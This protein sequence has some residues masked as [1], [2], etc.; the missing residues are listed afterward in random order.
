MPMEGTFDAT[1]FDPAQGTPIHPPA[2]KIP[3]TITDTEIV[4][5]SAGNGG[6]LAIEFTTPIGVH[7]GRYNL[8]S[9]S[10]KAK[11][12]AHKQL[13]ALCHA[14]GRYRLDW[15]N[16]G[17]ALRGGVG[18]IDINYQK[19]HDPASG[20]PEAKGYTET[21]RVYDAAGHEPGKRGQQA[22]AQQPQ[23]AL[24]A[25]ANAPLVN[26]GEQGLGQGQPQQASTPVPPNNWRAGSSPAPAQQAQSGGAWKP[27]AN[28]NAGNAP[29]GSR[30]N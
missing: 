20:L 15:K 14:T 9:Q 5:N 30:T 11:E 19:G 16:D 24:P 29:W 26:Q 13:S 4:D 10:D 23:T 12:I 3:F 17:A 7:I 25:P 1:Q 8:W 28:A 27:G 18:L 21:K 6:L 2:Q 22:S